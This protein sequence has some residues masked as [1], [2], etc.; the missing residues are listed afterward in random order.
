MSNRDWLLIAYLRLHGDG[1]SD[2]FNRAGKLR[3]NAVAG[4]PENAPPMVA[5][6]ALKRLAALVERGQGS[7]LVH[8]HQ[9]AVTDNVGGENGGNLTFDTLL[10]HALRPTVK[11]TRTCDLAVMWVRPASH[12]RNN[13]AMTVLS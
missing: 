5:D 7:F 12:D 2:G 13:A 6:R 4:A 1:A 11:T 10:G 9:P 3:Y 8:F